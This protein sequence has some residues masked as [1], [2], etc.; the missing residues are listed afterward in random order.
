[1]GKLAVLFA[2]AWL[3]LAM[4]LPELRPLLLVGV[5]S[6]FGGFVGGTQHRAKHDAEL[7]QA[8]Q[9]RSVRTVEA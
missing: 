5:F 3:V 1:M 2:A 9:A 7:S 6:W 4:V 8:R